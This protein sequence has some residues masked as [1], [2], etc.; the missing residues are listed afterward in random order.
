MKRFSFLMCIS[1]AI[2]VEIGCGGIEILSAEETS[3]FQ[4]EQVVSYGFDGTEEYSDNHSM[5][6][7]AIVAGYLYMGTANPY[8]GEV[9]RTSDGETWE[10]V[11]AGGFEGAGGDFKEAISFAGFLW[12]GTEGASYEEP[13]QIY[14][15]ATGDP[16][17][18]E[19]A[20]ADVPMWVGCITAFKVFKDAL[21]VGTQ[22]L[23]EIWRVRFQRQ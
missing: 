14:R 17:T 23:A 12:V 6:G 20:L 1:A 13:A 4:W 22:S 3:A 16:G 9:W 15:S 8:G 10:C 19:D 2:C 18:W 7:E 11:V 21:Y 5:Y